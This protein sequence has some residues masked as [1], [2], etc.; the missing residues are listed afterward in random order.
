MGI[1]IDIIIAAVCIFTVYKAY[2]N[3]LVKSVVG[4]AKGIVSLVSAYAFTPALSEYFYDKFVLEHISGGIADSISSVA[5]SEGGK[6]NLDKMFSEKPDVLEQIIDRYGTDEAKLGEMCKG[7]TEGTEE[8]V[9]SIAEYIASPIASGISTAVAFI[10][11]FVG[12]FLALSIVTYIVDAVF[13]LPVLKG[14][15]KLFGIL[16]GV[17]EA[18]LF[19][20]LIG[21][22]LAM[23]MGYLG[24]LDPNMFGD[25]AIE[26]SVFMRMMRSLDLLDL[27]DGIV[28]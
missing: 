7:F 25:K 22:G 23:L 1:V 27:S 2:R 6:F 28:K 3:G 10:L 26:G 4:F 18:L 13:H 19:S 8:T 5:R 20:V 15:N 11:L 24:S 12:I 16:F 17:G 9:D 14:V 21:Y